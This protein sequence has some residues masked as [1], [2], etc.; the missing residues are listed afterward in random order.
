M[1]PLRAWE[2]RKGEGEWREGEL[3]LG[4]NNL[5]KNDQKWAGQKSTVSPED[6]LH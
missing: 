2:H 1:H 5:R 4:A 6:G 3:E